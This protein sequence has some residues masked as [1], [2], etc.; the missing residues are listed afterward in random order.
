MKMILCFNPMMIDITFSSLHLR[1]KNENE[2]LFFPKKSNQRSTNSTTYFVSVRIAELIH[3]LPSTFLSY[4]NLCSSNFLSQVWASL[5]LR[6]ILLHILGVWLV[7]PWK[8][9]SAHIRYSLAYK[10]GFKMSS[11]PDFWPIVNFKSDFTQC[12]L[13][14]TCKSTPN[15]SKLSLEKHACLYARDY[16]ICT[17]ISHTRNKVVL[18]T[19]SGGPFL[20]SLTFLPILAA[21]MF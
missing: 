5:S 7:S 14:F 16:D 19:S 21:T 17:K 10:L 12:K 9:E 15:F 2:I 13:L 3:H 6:R 11:I 1:K 18:T 4:W 20:S 8:Q